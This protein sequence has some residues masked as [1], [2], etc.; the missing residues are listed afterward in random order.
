MQSTPLRA[1]EGVDCNP[2]PIIGAAKMIYRPEGLILTTPADFH[3]VAV[4]WALSIR[5]VDSACVYLGDL[6]VAAAA[7]L[8]ISQGASELVFRDMDGRRIGNADSKFFWNRRVGYP[9][10]PGSAHSSDRDIIER[11]CR[12]HIENTR[13]IFPSA[14]VMINSAQAQ[15]AATKKVIQLQTASMSGF[16]IP[17]TLISNDYEEIK[18]FVDRNPS[19]IKSYTTYSWGDGDSIF[20][21]FTSPIET[22]NPDDRESIE[23]CP[24]IYQARVAGRTEIR[25][26]AFGSYQFAIAMER[27]S[28]RHPEVV[29]SRVQLHYRNT[30]TYPIDVP[31]GVSVSITNYLSSL[32]LEYGAF[33]LIVDK[34]GNWVFLECNESGQFLFLEE[35]CPELPMLERFSGWL[36]SLCGHD[37]D[38]PSVSLRSFIEAGAEEM[39]RKDLMRHRSVWSYQRHFEE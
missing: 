28:D 26:V 32:G 33:D 4:S 3:A 5:G 6:P 22:I 25:L 10:A 8:H 18:E 24:E 11:S 23:L 12:T 30:R 9:T 38:G 16:K 2:H 35:L 36:A 13:M 17:K 34:Q 15:F 37:S 27:K 7:S 29:D 19:I 20:S 21:S 14:C 1:K 31:E 39:L